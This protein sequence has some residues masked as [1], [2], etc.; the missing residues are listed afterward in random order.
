M[1]DNQYAFTYTDYHIVYPSGIIKVFKNIKQK[2][3]LKDE[4]R[5]NYL[6]C[7]TVI[8]DSELLGKIYM[9][10]YRNRQDWGLWLDL[11][12]RTGYAYCYSFPLTFYRFRKD[13]ISSNKIKMIKY[14]WKIYRDHLQG[15]LFTSLFRLMNNVILHVY[16]G[17]RKSY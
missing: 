15:N 2:V 8:Y 14:H 3:K 17:L 10:Y 1:L 7:S 11:L 13:S 9:P 4:I 16:Y 12:K 6:A 5:F